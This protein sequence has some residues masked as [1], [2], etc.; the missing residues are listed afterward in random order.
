[1]SGGKHGSAQAELRIVSQRD[2]FIL[3]G[4][5]EQQGN[6]AEEF[7]DIGGR[8]LPDIRQDR[9]LHKGAS[10][11]HGATARERRIAAAFDKTA[12]RS[13]NVFV[14]HIEKQ[15]SAC[16]IAVSNSASVCSSKCLIR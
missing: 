4:D 15:A 7:F 10:A 3:V 12:P 16:V 8:G 2:G 9:R 13:V 6:G 1:M 11:I 5:A 14:R